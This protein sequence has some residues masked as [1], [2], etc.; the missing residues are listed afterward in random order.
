MSKLKNL[1]SECFLYELYES[2][3]WTLLDLSFSESIDTKNITDCIHNFAIGYCDGSQLR[4]RPN[5]DTFAIMFEK[6]GIK[7]WFHV[8]KWQLEDMKKNNLI[9]LTS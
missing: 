2:G 6:D 1:N 5:A 9:E 4:L 8:P 7:F 3:W